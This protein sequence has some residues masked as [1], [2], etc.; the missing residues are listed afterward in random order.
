MTKVEWREVSGWGKGECVADEVTDAAASEG[1]EEEEAAY[2]EEQL[3]K[4][5]NMEYMEKEQEKAMLQQQ[6][7]EE[8]EKRRFEELQRFKTKSKNDPDWDP[9]WAK[10]EL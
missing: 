3:K 1:V 2:Q 4:E 9:T 7:E 5:H 8:E 6:M 10:P